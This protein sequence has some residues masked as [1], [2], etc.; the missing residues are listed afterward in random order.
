MTDNIWLK[1]RVAVAVQH[2]NETARL[3]SKKQIATTVAN[4]ELC[5]VRNFSIGQGWCCVYD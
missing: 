1:S 5:M 3:Q 4:V 2:N